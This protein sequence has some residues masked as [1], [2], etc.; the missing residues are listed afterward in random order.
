[1]DNSASCKFLVGKIKGKPEYISHFSALG[2][3]AFQFHLNIRLLWLFYH[4]CPSWVGRWQISEC[5]YMVLLPSVG[6]PSQRLSGHGI[7]THCLSPWNP[8]SWTLWKVKGHRIILTVSPWY[9]LQKYPLSCGSLKTGS[10]AVFKSPN[11]FCL[12]CYNSGGKLYLRS[13]V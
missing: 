8:Q 6:S 5:S 13:V 11:Q 12:W 9:S 3:D 4:Q 2:K 10:E 1:M 7:L